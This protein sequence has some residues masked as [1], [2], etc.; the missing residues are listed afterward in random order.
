MRRFLL[1]IFTIFFLAGSLLSLSA[2]QDNHEYLENFE[3][4][5]EVKAALQQ[6]QAYQDK[7][8]KIR[9]TFHNIHSVEGNPV[10]NKNR[11]STLE[12]KYL[13]EIIAQLSMLSAFLNQD[14]DRGV[15]TVNYWRRTQVIISWE[16]YLVSTLLNDM[17]ARYKGKKLNPLLRTAIASVAAKL[18]QDMKKHDNSQEDYF[19]YWEE[20]CR[21]TVSDMH[22][23]AK[24]LQ[25]IIK[26]ANFK[27]PKNLTPMVKGDLM[28]IQGLI[29]KQGK[30]PINTKTDN[31]YYW[32]AT[33]EFLA[34]K[35]AKTF[36]DLLK[37]T[38][39]EHLQKLVEQEPL[40]EL[41][42]VSVQGIVDDIDATL[43]KYNFVY[44]SDESKAALA[45]IKVLNNAGQSLKTLVDSLSN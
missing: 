24:N 4:Y 5:P 2:A 42:K 8:N 11:A 18:E 44:K 41:L 28:V 3:P 45:I 25:L 38:L 33:F 14:Y 34:R 30:V 32:T 29:L 20:A 23:A 17:L 31:S 6:Y 19:Y 36:S 13:P 7:L 1:S 12:A 43:K 35:Q 15:G 40:M 37:L 22:V 21:S 27:M 39:K 10:E 9:E 16:G 26:S